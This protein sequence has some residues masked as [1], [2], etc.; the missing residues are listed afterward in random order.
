[1]DKL[2][3]SIRDDLQILCGDTVGPSDSTWQDVAG[4]LA[5]SLR[6]LANQVEQARAGNA[7]PF[8]VFPSFDEVADLP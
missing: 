4:T 3:R 2:L 7:Q 1:M 6:G 5:V 8:I